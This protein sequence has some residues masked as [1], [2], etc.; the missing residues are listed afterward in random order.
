MTKLIRRKTCHYIPLLNHVLWAHLDYNRPNFETHK[1]FSVS[2][3][4]EHYDTVFT[5]KL[6]ME[7]KLY[8]HMQKIYSFIWPNINLAKEHKYC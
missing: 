7:V 6:I 2:Y 5:R 3:K 8:W 4:M 1:S